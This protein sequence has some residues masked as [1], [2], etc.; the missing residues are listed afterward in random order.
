MLETLNRHYLPRAAVLFRP[1]GEVDPLLAEL[2]PYVRDMDMIDGQATA[3][4]CV[5]QAC[6][7]PTTDPMEMILRLSTPAV[8]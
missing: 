4:V 3:Y 8:K 6:H 7:T 5:N 2:A 1:A